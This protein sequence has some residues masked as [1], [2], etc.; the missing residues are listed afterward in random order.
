MFYQ[1]IYFAPVWI[2][3]KSPRSGPTPDPSVNESWVLT[4]NDGWRVFALGFSETIHFPGVV[5]EFCVTFAP[6]QFGSGPLDTLKLR[7]NRFYEWNW[8][9][10]PP[11]TQT[12]GHAWSLS[13]KNLSSDSYIW[14]K[15]FFFL[16]TQWIVPN[17]MIH[18]SI[19]LFYTIFKTKSII[20]ETFDMR[21]IGIYKSIF[22]LSIKTVFMQY[23]YLICVVFSKARKMQELLIDFYSE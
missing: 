5:E 15:R 3:L 10:G 14:L 23:I 17:Q 12:P 13:A 7:F 16:L 11:V 4:A 1:L 20:Y 19:I 9:C 6:S 8:W 2:T 18:F 21:C 22:W